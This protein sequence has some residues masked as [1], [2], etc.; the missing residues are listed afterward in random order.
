ML[1][2]SISSI[3]F[4]LVCFSTICPTVALLPWLSH[5]T[6]FGSGITIGRV[7]CNARTS[8]S[9]GI[10]HDSSLGLGV[11]TS[12]SKK[13][14]RKISSN[15]ILTAWILSCTPAPKKELLTTD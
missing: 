5:I 10:S 8:T 14:R 6:F 12:T 13:L 15:S 11:E 7:L 2:S 1:Q 3:L 4:S 9:F